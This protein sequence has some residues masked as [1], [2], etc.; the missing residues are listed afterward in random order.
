MGR[1]CHQRGTCPAGAAGPG[2]PRRRAAAAG[3]RAAPLT[4]E[5]QSSGVG[6]EESSKEKS[7]CCLSGLI[8]SRDNPRA[9]R[10]SCFA[11]PGER[12][13]PGHG[14]HA[15]PGPSHVPLVGMNGERS[16]LRLTSK[17]GDLQ[18]CPCTRTCVLRKSGLRPDRPAEHGT[19]APAV[20]HLLPRWEVAGKPFASQQYLPLGTHELGWARGEVAL[21]SGQKKTPQNSSLHLFVS[22]R[23]WEQPKPAAA[24]LNGWAKR[25]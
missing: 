7:D 11:L 10:P 1:R 9:S 24:G 18:C 15:R 21:G 22:W 3:R 12:K 19:S 23:C 14:L 2:Q 4:L 25:H 8:H 6:Q 16:A 17:R 20:A 5:R 13:A